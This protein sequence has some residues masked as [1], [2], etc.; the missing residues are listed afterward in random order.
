M[1]GKAI[2]KERIKIKQERKGMRKERVLVRKEGKQSK[3]T[4]ERLSVKE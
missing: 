4:E 3:E 2:S 1:E